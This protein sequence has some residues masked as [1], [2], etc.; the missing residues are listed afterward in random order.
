M[1]NGVL[2]GED[3]P[4]NMILK[5]NVSTL[6]EAFL[7]LCCIQDDKRVSIYGIL[8]EKKYIYYKFEHIF[9]MIAGTKLLY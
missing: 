3:S 1:R 4:N 7:S 8:E 2:V 5:Q 9:N 6:E